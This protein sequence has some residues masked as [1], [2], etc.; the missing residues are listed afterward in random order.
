MGCD[1]AAYDSSNCI[2][3]HFVR[4]N[5]GG[6]IAFIGN[7][8]YGWYMY[9]S[10]DTYSMGYDVHFFKS[11]FQENL[12]HL[13][14]AFSD[15]KNNGYQDNPGNDYYKYIFTELTLLGDPELP[16][17]TDSPMSFT[18]THPDQLPVGTSSF[19]VSVSSGGS[20]VNQAYVCLWK[21]T[22]VYLTGFTDSNGVITFDVT[23]TS[24]G[25]LL[26][27]VTKQNY[28]PYKG[29]TTVMNQRPNLL[30]G[31]ITGQLFGVSTEIK[32]IG[33]ASASH[34]I[35]NIK[36]DGGLILSGKTMNGTFTALDVNDTQ[37]IKDVPIIGLGAVTI[38]ITVSAEGIPDITK[39][40]NGF[41]FVIFVKAG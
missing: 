34:I 20:P 19:T 14:A 30:I 35:W 28:L 39:T 38:T 33:N 10:Y 21:G 8:R 17:W 7:S 1:P 13:G 25:T 29:S 15:H 23:S 3:E 5:N 2:A 26:V 18:V 16:I 36:I 24:P 22:E 27:T 9:G 32:N 12:Y 41:V 11:L 4:N 40:A 31:P 37:L 6:G